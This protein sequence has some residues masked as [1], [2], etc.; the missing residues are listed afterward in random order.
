MVEQMLFKDLKLVDSAGNFLNDKIKTYIDE[1][2]KSASWK[3]V[4]NVAFK[5]CSKEAPKYAENYQQAT[6]IPKSDCDFKFDAV[7]D[8]VDI[9]SFGVRK[10]DTNSNYRADFIQ[11]FPAKCCYSHLNN[12]FSLTTS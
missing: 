11:G 2:I 3:K 5:K 4:V 7:S 10:I 9:A 1:T 8:C 6:G 12:Q